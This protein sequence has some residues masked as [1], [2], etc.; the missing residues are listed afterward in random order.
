[1]RHIVLGIVLVGGA[2]A[3][4][5]A[6]A[7]GAAG[8]PRG[9]VPMA[10]KQAGHCSAYVPPGWSIQSNPQASATD[11]ISPDRRAYAGWGVRHVNR[12]MESFYG[13]LH[14]DPE[15]AA[16]YVAGQVLQA[17]LGDAG[18]VRYTSPPQ[19][20]LGYFTLRRFETARSQGL[21]FYRSY[22]GMT[23][24]EYIG[25]S[26]FAI[27][28]KSLGATGLM[29]ASGVATSIR[30]QTQLVP[31]RDPGTSGGGS[32]GK[33]AG[34]GGEGSLRGYNKELGHQ[35]AHSST[36]ENFLLDHATQWQENGPQ[37]AGYYKQNGN[38]QEKLELGRSDDC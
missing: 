6:A 26:Y 27:A 25:S 30:C 32:G 38:F 24:Q 18:S 1:M 2:C 4:A 34:C 12:A 22:A 28:D 13:P 36:G 7:K 10:V 14:G 35:Y 33:R 8:L 23:A 5:Q 21:V 20:F 9:G 19:S 31:R 17:V 3:F 11:L 16:A 15:R 37:G 29:V